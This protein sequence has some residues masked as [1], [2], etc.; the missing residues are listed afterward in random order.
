MKKEIKDI[1][2]LP[3][4]GVTIFPEMVMHFDVGREKSLKAIEEAMKQ[5]EMILAVSQR[6]A[7]VDEPKREDLYE[8]GTLVEIKQ[9]VKVG[10]DQLK[11]L[12]K[13][14]AR[15]KI[16]TLQDE[17][18]MSADVEVIKDKLIEAD[19]EEQALI[20]TIAELFEKYASINPRITDE[21]LYGILGLK[22]SIEMM[23]II[24]GHI[25][26]EVEKKQAI[27]EC[28]DIK[29]RMFKIIT[30]L[31][32]EIEILTLQKEIF[33]KVK[34]NIDQSQKEYFLREQVKIIQEQ[35]GDKDG[36]QGDIDKY[37]EQ[38]KN[39]PEFVKE[40]IE[41]EIR[42]LK[43]TPASSPDNGNIRTYIETVLD[44][45]WNHYTKENI[46]LKKAAEILD[47]EH[48]GL[49]KVKERVL[50]YLAVRSL[51]EESPA[52]ILCLVGP[53]GVGKTSIAK[54]IAH[55]TGRN[56]VRI[57]LGGVRD[58]AE[59][60]GHRRT[61]VGSIPG[62]FV[63]GISEAKSMNPLILL[64]EIDKMASDF[65]GDPAAALLEILD[66]KQNNS[67]KDHYLELPLDLSKVLFVAT[68]NSLSTVP[69]PLLDRMEIIEVGSYTSLEK[70]EIAMKYLLPNQLKAHHLD[71]KQIKF[72]RTNILYL[73]EHYTK[74]AGVRGL[75]RMLAKVCR[76]AAREIVEQDIASIQITPKKLGEYLGSSS[77]D[78]EL[79]NKEPEVGIVRGLAW[80][81]VGGD[82]LSI[83]VNCMP[84]KG[85]LELTGQMGNVMKESAKAAMSYI[86]SKVNEL[87]IAEDFYVKNDLHI[88]IPE[89]AVPKDGPSAG[90][91][92][93]TAMI[94][95]LTNKPVK[96]DLAMTGEITI[97]GRVLPIGGLK[98]KL[99]A[100]KRAKIKHVI[101]PDQNKKNVEELENHIVEGL[102]ISFVHT[103]DEVL[104]YVFA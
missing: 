36:I 18:Y 61:Y 96:A 26:L 53:P 5:N 58:E 54:S 34:Q 10:E 23:D 33:N 87:G 68:A 28:L 42:R 1:P 99:L 67:F 81:S 44:I 104:Q 45:P 73:I 77:F 38:L 8:I 51:A 32:A 31:E 70:L 82:T 103:M 59:I 98:E 29:E 102:K 63:Y 49:E 37:N 80:T 40:K 101:V 12:V 65:K 55:A 3:L 89:G 76:K 41:K 20:R 2:V 14:T 88:H 100:A 9:T 86:R 16:L 94:S 85:Q 79:K 39:T 84:G 64:D 24:I 66:S 30:I 48:Y 35:L 22:N 25:V 6:D 90:I 46:Q 13:G 19:K 17:T 92:M 71:K 7:D 50:E 74:E 56:D 83:E 72:S 75:E 93:A 11:V 69:K 27:L 97:R 47:K 62:R 95:A 21:V 91:T 15:A 52:P 4:R 78:Y 57:S 43:N 60:R